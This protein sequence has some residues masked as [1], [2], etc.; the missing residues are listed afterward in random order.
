MQPHEDP[1]SARRDGKLRLHPLPASSTPLFGRDADLGTIGHLLTSEQVRLL[2]LTGFGGTGKTRLACAAAAQVADAFSGAIYFVDLSAVE[3]PAVVPASVAQAVGIQDSG[4]EPLHLILADVLGERRVLLILDN[5]EQVLDAADLVSDLLQRCPELA[6]LVT[7]REPLHVRAEFV[8]SVAPLPVP[9][10]CPADPLQAA[11]NP[12]IALFLDRARAC[13]PS[14][15]LTSDNL[16]AVAEICTRLDGLPLAIELAA[17]QIRVLSPMAILER[18]QARAPF[19]LGAARDAPARHRTLRAAVAS[20]YDLLAPLEQSVFRW[21]SVFAGG[22]TASAAAA[23]CAP[24][25]PSV[26][27]LGVL[28]SLADKSLMLAGEEPNGEPR[29]RWLETIRTEA[30]DRLAEQGELAEARQ[31]HAV[32]C[33]SLAEQADAASIGRSMGDTYD[34]LER[35]YDNFRAAFHWALDGGDLGVGLALAGS[36]YRF[37]MQRGHLSEARQWLSRALPRSGD[38]PAATR[39]RALNAA[40]V[41]AGMQDDNTASE[42]YLVDSL[43]LWREVGDN[44]RMAAVVG[45][46]GLVAQNRHD[47]DRALACFE[48]SEALY[49][50]AGDQRGIAISIGC[51]A[52][53]ARQRGE[54]LEAR[55][56]FEQTVGLFR[57]LGEDLYL[58]NS[59]ANLGHTALALGNLD[60]AGTSFRESL[61]IRYALGNTLNM[62]EC[63]EG[64]AA[65]AGAA[66]HPRRAARLY[67]AADA[68]REVTGAPVSTTDRAEH[69]ELLG[70]IRGRL[71][72]HSFQSEWA[73]GR[74]LELDEAVRLAMQSRATGDVADAV[75]SSGLAIL[76]RREREVAAHVASGLTNREIAREL[77]VAER[78]VETHL[79]HIFDKLGAQTRAEVA[80]WVTRQEMEPA[81]SSSVVASRG[82]GRLGTNL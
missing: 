53:L 22:F 10:R 5:F 20:S 57:A 23:V 29:F 62:A 74:A 39:A 15:A 40:G 35:E 58:A 48:E 55:A 44:M 71:G 12:A 21:C 41:L 66:G 68:L 51:R 27:V 72:E 77:T 11:A 32:H 13:R 61:E 1:L 8:Y 73:A 67:G 43:A 54:H 42:A 24:I 79:E 14:F 37:W 70:R 64:F 60:E 47:I 6:V 3:D 9:G 82:S 18:L 78:T 38:L 46:L 25:P 56:L 4:S 33:L 17:A 50:A 36:L 52:R 76:T 7:T 49:E 81:Q 28:A 16:P 34:L 75:A 30:L 26:D 63:L 65:L 31:R 59:L 80:V 69:E 2:S 19:P 45:N